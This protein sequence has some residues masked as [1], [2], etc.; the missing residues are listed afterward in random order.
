MPASSRL[1]CQ[2]LRNLALLVV[3]GLSGCAAINIQEVEVD[4]LDI[5]VELKQQ[6]SLTELDV[7]LSRGIWSQPVRMNDALIAVIY[8]DG[9]SEALVAANKNGRYGLRNSDS[10]AIHGLQVDPIGTQNMPLITPVRIAEGNQFDGK[11]FF[12]DDILTLNLTESAGDERYLVATGRCGN[13]A[14][15]S[16]HKITDRATSMEV[17]LGDL[18]AR[19]NNAA[20]ADLSGIIPITLTLEERYRPNWTLPFNIGELTASDSVRFKIDTSGFRFRAAV[21]VQL[22]SNLLMQIQ[23][24]A[25]DVRYCY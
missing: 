25:W 8:A 2:S 9:S 19:V 13:N 22:A 15:S 10:R 14:Y 21:T 1:H 16:E 20:E 7:F 11:S 6:A 17:R 18:M 3:A 5:R 4:K 24:Q 12:K 23:N